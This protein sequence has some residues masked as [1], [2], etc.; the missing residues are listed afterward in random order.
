MGAA[1]RKSRGGITVTGGGTAAAAV[2]QVTITLG[3]E[4]LRP[5]PG[6]AFTTAGA[7]VTQV[8][9]VLADNGVDARSVRTADLSL[10]PRIEW[11]DNRETLLGYQAAQQLIVHLEALGEVERILTDVV[12]RGGLG[13]RIHQVALEAGDTENATR[14]ARVAAFGDAVAAAQQFAELAGRTLGAVQE[15]SEGADVQYVYRGARPAAKAMSASM[16][17]ATGDTEV[18]V[19]VRVRWAFAD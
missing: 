17:V 5:D 2:D 16:P 1:Q 11:Q 3:V 10:G 7:T 9:S 6:E 12:R 8:L 15:V 18:S 13:V 4:I 14:V 19:T